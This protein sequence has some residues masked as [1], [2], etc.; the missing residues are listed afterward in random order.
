MVLPPKKSMRTCKRNGRRSG[1]PFLMENTAQ[2]RGDGWKFRNQMGVGFD[3]WESQRSWIGL[4]SKQ[5]I[6]NWFLYLSQYSRNTVTDLDR[7]EAH[8]R[9]CYKLNHISEQD[10]TG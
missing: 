4:S 3:N 10:A 9:Q 8:T 6:R 5:S 7:I 1:R 2:A